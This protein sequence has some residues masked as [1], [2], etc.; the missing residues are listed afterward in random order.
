MIRAKAEI[1]CEGI[2]AEEVGPTVFL[3]TS[4]FFAHASKLLASP[5]VAPSTRLYI[6][7]ET[8]ALSASSPLLPPHSR[9]SWVLV[10]FPLS[11]PTSRVTRSRPVPLP[12]RLS[13]PFLQSPGLRLVARRA[14]RR[15]SQIVWLNSSRH[16]LETSQIL[17]DGKISIFRRDMGFSFL[18]CHH[19]TVTFRENE[20]LCIMI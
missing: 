9:P 2:K 5:A 4:V 18:N 16:A 15:H 7:L 6:Q 20:Y 8:C 11:T 1:C 17:L 3:K 14:A 13:R 19:R 12:S 10:L